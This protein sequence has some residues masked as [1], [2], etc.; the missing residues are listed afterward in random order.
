MSGA[1]CPCGRNIYKL[2][3]DL[4]SAKILDRLK[5]EKIVGLRIQLLE[6][7]NGIAE[8][9][10]QKR[11]LEKSNRCNKLDGG[12]GETLRV[13]NTNSKG[14]DDGWSKNSRSENKNSVD[15][16]IE[17]LDKKEEWK[18]VKEQFI[19]SNGL[20]DEEPWAKKLNQSTKGVQQ[21]H[22]ST[23]DEFRGNNK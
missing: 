3:Q 2:Q 8:L 17:S 18:L 13:H 12:W 9:Q 23:F 7:H 20:D 14:F 11:D 10:R 19:L 5:Y 6:A 1:N 22:H 21:N 15:V 4:V 16:G